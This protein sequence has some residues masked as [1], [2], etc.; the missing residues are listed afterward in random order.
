[1]GKLVN[2]GL[3]DAIG[4]D[5]SVPEGAAGSNSQPT[6]AP[7]DYYTAI[8]TDSG[9]LST[10]SNNATSVPVAYR[11]FPPVIHAR[12]QWKLSK[13]FH[14]Y[15]EKPDDRVFAVSTH[16]GYTGRYPRAVL[17]NGP[18]D[19]DPILAVAREETPAT[20]IDRYSLNSVIELPPVDSSTNSGELVKEIMQTHT[21]GQNGVGYWFPIEVNHGGKMR[22]ENFE[23]RKTKKG[24]DDDLQ[25]GG[26][27]LLRLSSQEVE[28]NS[29]SSGATSSTHRATAEDGHEVV[30]VFK[31]NNTLTNMMH[32]FE[33]HF[34]G[35]ALSGSLGERWSLMVVITALRLWWLHAGFRANRKTAE[36][37]EQ[38][39]RH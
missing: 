1:M 3:Q 25:G 24:S 5:P 26:F 36:L 7:P 23:W 20:S 15:S 29:G 22:N 18:N 6:E 8:A 38:Y 27:K 34:V 30:A 21:V 14:L 12:Y 28:A 35:D 32:P 16:A 37:G 2:A 9:H 39:N 19:K 17:H 33:V 11:P 4:N 13:T 31:W 10:P